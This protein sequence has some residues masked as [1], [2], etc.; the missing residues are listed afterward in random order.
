[1]NW[2]RTSR[3]PRAE[4]EAD[5]DGVGDVA[6]QVAQAEQGD[7]QLD[8]ADQEGEQ[9]GGRDPIPLGKD[10][11]GTEQGDGDGVGRAR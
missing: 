10:R 1:M 9:D 8:R 2:S 11:Q 3:I 7:A 6:G 4:G 5:D